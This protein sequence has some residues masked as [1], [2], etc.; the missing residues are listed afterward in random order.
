MPTRLQPGTILE[1]QFTIEY[2]IGQC[3]DDEAAGSNL[4]S[5]EQRISLE[6]I[7]TAGM[8]VPCTDE[9]DLAKIDELWNESTEGFIKRNHATLE[10]L[11]SHGTHQQRQFIRRH[12]L[13]RCSGS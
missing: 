10:H 1:L 3:L 11:A 5:A 6:W 7:E 4:F 8:F 2:T 13:P 9:D 12:L